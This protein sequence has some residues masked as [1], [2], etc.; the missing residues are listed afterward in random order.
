M[1]V[2]VLLLA[3]GA[4]FIF[5]LVFFL[6]FRVNIKGYVIDVKNDNLE[7]P[8]GFKR[9]SIR[10]SAIRHMEDHQTK[11]KHVLEISGDF[12]TRRFSF[13]SES[14]R[15]QLH[16]TLEN[17]V[18][19]EQ[20]SPEATGDNADCNGIIVQGREWFGIAAGLFALAIICWAWFTDLELAEK[21]S[22]IWFLFSGS[23]AFLVALVSF[24]HFMARLKGCVID[25]ENDTLEY[26]NPAAGFK[27]ASVRLSA[28]RQLKTYQKIDI[29]SSSKGK[30]R[31]AKEKWEVL[32]ISGDFGDPGDPDGSVNE[33]RFFF[34]SKS[35]RDKLYQELEKLCN[36]PN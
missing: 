5:A 14:R 26:P 22:G 32:E 28:I 21:A 1:D 2:G 16:Q 20:A 30:S 19:I 35:K 13:A 4:G 15:D 33:R 12:G 17:Y 24:L 6:S 18:K 8:A 23:I 10:L 25:I 27:R 3:G 36:L 11:T 7:Y 9:G 31:A 29:S 34:A